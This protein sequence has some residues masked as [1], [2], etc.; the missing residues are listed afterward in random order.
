MEM[1][2]AG[3]RR[4]TGQPGRPGAPRTPPGAPPWGRVLVTTISLW[5]SRRLSRLSRLRRPRLALIAVICVLA[6]AAAAA[7]VVR[8]A[9][10]SSRADGTASAAGPPRAP[11]PPL[12]PEM[13]QAQAA[14]WIAGQVSRNATIACDPAACTALGARGVATTRLV[15]LSDSASGASS[16]SDASVAVAADVIV[17]SGPARARL[18]RVAPGLLASFGSGD[19]AIDVRAAAPGGAAAYQDAAQADLAAR[20]SGGRQLL[21][22]KR[23]QIDAEGAALLQAGQVDSRLLIMLAMLGSQHTWR[24]VAFGGAS[25]GA[26]ASEAPLRQVTIADASGRA[27]PAQAADLA[28]ALAMVRAQQGPYQPA[29]VSTVRVGG[30]QQGLSFDFAA[31]TPL[32][33]LS[34]GSP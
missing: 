25:P 17:A 20:Q 34:G 16:A 12:A 8:L 21:H 3:A 29:H 26:P 27:A 18:G 31:P 22:S 4:Q 2:F 33:L 14:A 5:T 11:A 23:I 7:G 1:E 13:A 6:V 28:A 15:P 30:A 32:G 24:V 19:S 9:G 10:T